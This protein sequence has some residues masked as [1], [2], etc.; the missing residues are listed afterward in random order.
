MLAVSGPELVEIH[1]AE[2][3][4]QAPGMLVTPRE[5]VSRRRGC[6]SHRGTWQ[7]LGISV[8]PWD[9]A[10]A[11]DVGHTVGPGSCGGCWSHQ[12]PSARGCSLVTSLLGDLECTAVPVFPHF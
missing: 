8:T 9:W 10:A 5:R 3:G 4:E 7:L 1:P 6:R 2:T 11:G 12:L